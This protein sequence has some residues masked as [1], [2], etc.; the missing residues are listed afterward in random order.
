MINKIL[1]FWFKELEP[2]QWFVKNPTLD[3]TIKE[4]F[5]AI[6]HDIVNGKCED[7]KASAEGCLALVIVLDQLSRNMFRDRPQAF[8]ADLQAMKTAEAAIEGG[9]D[10]L[11]DETQRRFLY[12]PFMHSENAAVHQKAVELFTALGNEMTLEY[13]YKHKAIIDRF[14]RYPHRNKILGRVSTPEEIE[15]L[16]GP[17]SSF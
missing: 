3:A 15:F 13:E 5:E 11:L 12:M 6:Y 1:D 2:S 17:D 8:A 10:Q 9:F 4:K 7:W 14:G 16:S